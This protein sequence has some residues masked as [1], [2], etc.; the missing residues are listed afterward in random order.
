MPARPTIRLTLPAALAAL[1]LLAACGGGAP[2]PTGDGD[3]K[4]EEALPLFGPDALV[5]IRTLTESRGPGEDADGNDRRRRAQEPRTGWKGRFTTGPEAV[6]DA[7]EE[8]AVAFSATYREASLRHPVLSRNGITVHGARAP[9]TEGQRFIGATMDHA[10]FAVF[11]G[12]D[13]GGGIYVRT[14]LDPA[15]GGPAES[16]TWTGVM[17]GADRAGRD[18][19]MGDAEIEYDFADREVDVRL[20]R[21]VNLDAEKAHSTP[22]VKFTDIAAGAD[23]RWED[24][25]GRRYVEVGLAGP[26]H[27][28]A[29]G[30][31]RTPDMTGA[32]GA[33]RTP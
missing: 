17:L 6:A 18:L 5:R 3:P 31:F 4:P 27:A 15:P 12:T 10:G 20:T 16:A 22:M 2:S 26:G 29:A 21:I 32:F 30:L 25:D 8:A 23:G 19:L 9:G 28:E 11:A 24:R 13:P 7:P 1:L 14:D 33:K